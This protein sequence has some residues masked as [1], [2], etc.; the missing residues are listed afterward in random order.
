MEL[1]E[2][3]SDDEIAAKMFE[4]AAEHLDISQAMLVGDAFLED[5]AKI[6]LIAD[7]FRVRARALIARHQN[8]RGY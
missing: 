4:K 5:R 1:I 3:L 7:G 6:K 8:L 2:I